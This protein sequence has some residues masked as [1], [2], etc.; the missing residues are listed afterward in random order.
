MPKKSRKLKIRASLHKATILTQPT[1][2]TQ[3]A[4]TREVKKI[5]PLQKAKAS[6]LP[7]LSEEEKQTTSYFRTD[8]RKSIIFIAGIITLEIILYFVTMSTNFRSILK[9]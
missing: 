1:Q 7:N 9:F 2:P 5:E 4:E 8:L 3:S 6:S